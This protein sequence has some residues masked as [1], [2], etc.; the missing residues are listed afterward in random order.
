MQGNRG[1]NTKPEIALRRLIFGMGYRYRLHDPTLPGTPDI[2]FPRRRK[3][4]FLHGCFWHQHNSDH[5][6]LRSYP[7]SNLAYWKAKLQRN[8]ERDE[9]QSLALHAC[10]WKAKIVWECELRSSATL[11]K[12]IR[13]FLGPSYVEYGP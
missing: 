9:T 5:C 13:R 8:I 7:R 2:V 6:P 12:T 3:V 10:G 11:K 1:K 4:I